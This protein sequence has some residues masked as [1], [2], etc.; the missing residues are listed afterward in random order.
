MDGEETFSSIDLE[1]MGVE[2]KTLTGEILDA[3]RGRTE[4]RKADILFLKPSDMKDRD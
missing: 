2:Q 4:Y 3:I 1:A